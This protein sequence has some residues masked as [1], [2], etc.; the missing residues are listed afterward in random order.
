MKK[1]AICY[2]LIVIF[3]GACAKKDPILPGHRTPVFDSGEIVAENRVIPEGLIKMPE[4]KTAESE[5]KFEQDSYNVIWQVDADGTRKK[6]FSGL[7]TISRVDVKR[8]PVFA[9]GFVYSGLSTGEVVKV[10]IRTRE[11]VWVADVYKQT[12]LTG[13][14]TILDIVAPVIVADG[15]VFAGGL[16]DAFCKINDKNGK[17]IWCKEIG[18]GVPFLIAGAVAF[19]VGTDNYLYAIDTK[20]GDIFWRVKTK[21]GC[22]PK[23]S[24]TDSGEF[25]ITVG[26]ETFAADS[27]KLVK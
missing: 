8:T 26:V 13:G 12:M 20:N 23:I 6:I 9:N 27:G 24:E 3:L 21:A 10:N 18:T 15:A 2:L 22:T 17:I 1:F 19:I 25:R 16:G 11:P 7:P 5:I 4:T 14:A